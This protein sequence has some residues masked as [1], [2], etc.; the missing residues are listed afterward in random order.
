MEGRDH[1]AT[2]PHSLRTAF[3]IF[4]GDNWTE[5]M[6]DAMASSKQSMHLQILYRRGFAQEILVSIL[7]FNVHVIFFVCLLCMY[8][9]DG[10]RTDS[11]SR[12]HFALDKLQRLR[13]V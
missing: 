6:F 13:F 2:L 5:V 12:I 3:I 4:T 7:T 1:F 9:K 11:G 8:R 10:P